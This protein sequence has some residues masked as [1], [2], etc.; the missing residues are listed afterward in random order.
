[1][2]QGSLNGMFFVRGKVMSAKV[3]C[4]REDFLLRSQKLQEIRELG[5][6]P[7][8]YEF[9]NRSSVESLLQE[10]SD[11]PLG[12][13][14]AAMNKTTPRVKFAGRLVLFRSMG[15]NA[16]GQL[17][18]HSQK[19]QVMFNRD[20]THVAG[21]SKDA[22]ISSI[23]F[24]EKKLDI[25][26]IL[27]IEGF[28]FF[29]HSG[30]LTVLVETV[31]LLCKSLI[32][33]PDKH[34]GLSDK[35]VRYRKRWLDLICSQEV[36]NVF[37]Q[38]SRIIKLI[39]E[40]M[41]SQG[42]LEVETPILQSI[43]GG[44]EARPFTTELEALHTE[45]FLRISLE[46]A[47][48]KILVGGA[49]KIYEIGKV[50]RNEGIDRTHN[51]EFTMIEAYTAYM[52]YHGV[53]EFVENLVEYVVRSL[54]H[55]STVI[56]YS[57]WKEGPQQ[58]D[59]KA[60]WKRMT[61]KESIKEYGGVDVDLYGDA[62]LREIVRTKTSLP[63][64]SF[65]KASRG[66]LVALLFDELVSENLIAP[67]HITDHPIETTPL[68]KSLRSGDPTYVERFESFCLGKELCNAYSE[69]NDPIVQRKLLEE[70]QLRKEQNPES[71][72]HP[73]DEEFL[74]ALCQGMPPSGGF[75][76]GIDRLVMILTDSASIRDVL[77]FPVMRRLS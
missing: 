55:G 23:K 46:I 30:E 57:H 13:S 29:T 38:R 63:E 16:F 42:Y 8:P 65:I 24:I 20:F 22:G 5:I 1:M 70:Q 35:E 33:L 52:D 49:P 73:I 26:D 25:G 43:Y 61:M 6:E 32:S 34:A 11:K 2:V 44:A 50:F 45:M 41:D 67:H 40:Y 4:D 31:T 48:K 66:A 53:M 3:E 64:E 60:P 54:N 21:L 77:Y 72:C 51:P 76:I 15:K 69:L 75:G 36:S 9:S 58:V 7:Y 27:G 59:F 39:R 47:L 19:I 28:L 17:L 74:E 14:E 10:F 12:D 68:C 56:T 37:V 18:D 71:E 62:E